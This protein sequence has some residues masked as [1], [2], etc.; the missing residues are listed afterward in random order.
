MSEKSIL[1]LSSSDV[2]SCLS[3]PDAIEAMR[4]A[5]VQLSSGKAIVPQRIHTKI[6][7]HDAMTLIMPV[8]L[9]S[10]T[11][12]GIKTV[13]VS[14][15]N[16]EKGLPLIHALVTVFDAETGQP[17]AIMDGASLTAIRTGAA[18]GLATNLLARKDTRVAA[19]IGAGRQGRKQLEAVCAVRNIEK[20][21]II[22]RN[23][24]Q[25]EKFIYDFKD[26]IEVDLVAADDMDRLCEVDII[27]T[28]TNSS[29]PVFGDNNVS[30]GTHIN[31]V[32]SY[33]PEMQEIPLDTVAR[34]RI[35]VD[36]I[37]SNLE[38]AGDII[39]PLR[40]GIISEHDIVGEIGQVASGEIEGR[41]SDDEITFFKSVGNA[42]QD[43]AAASVVL[44]NACQLR[45]GT[46]IRL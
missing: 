8:Y 34:S 25:S 41:K 1:V 23:P 35:F 40:H 17:L 18:S 6:N 11:K 38:E 21:Y 26:K 36:S 39:I 29:E 27:C 15:K 46:K 45:L 32:G 28:A 43:L 22:D 10:E 37:T 33:T 20:V 14:N 16:P 31:G 30:N 7:E 3:M 9:P 24:N 42:V 12:I 19:I 44:K 2:E 5:F 13:T 4:G